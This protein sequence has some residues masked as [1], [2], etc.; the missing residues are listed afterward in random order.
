MG[1]RRECRG[2]FGGNEG[3]LEEGKMGVWGE[4]MYLHAAAKTKTR[5]ECK[6]SPEE[7]CQTV[8]SGAYTE[9]EKS[10]AKERIIVG[11]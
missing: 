5:A 4:W 6:L 1:C 8:K 2:D 7:G 10:F 3:F 11:K 9:H